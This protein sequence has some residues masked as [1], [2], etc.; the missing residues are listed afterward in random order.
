MFGFEQPGLELT[1][2]T[3][4]GQYAIAIDRFSIGA[5]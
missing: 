2:Q 4:V 1:L 5:S 3:F